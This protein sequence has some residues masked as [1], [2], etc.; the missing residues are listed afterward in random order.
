MWILEIKIVGDDSILKPLYEEQIEKHK[1][2][3]KENKFPDSGFDIYCPLDHT[4][5][6]T[7]L[8]DTQIQCALY[9]YPDG[10]TYSDIKEKEHRKPSAY[11]MY[12]RS[13]IYKTSYRLANNTGIIDSGYRGNLKAAMD[14]HDL[15]TR[16][17]TLE[18]G[19]RYWQLCSPDLKP[20]DIVRL[21][22]E[23]DETTRGIGGHGSTGD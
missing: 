20:F 12:T 8:V 11:Y 2:M 17:P 19:K 22:E 15:P 14:Y 13:S 23:L 7:T 5:V 21:V 1:I 4:N 6:E 10:I 3:I 16:N 18:Q 9:E